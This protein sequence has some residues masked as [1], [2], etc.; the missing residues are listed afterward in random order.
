MGTHADIV[1]PLPELCLRA[2]G[3]SG[4]DTDTDAADVHVAM[5]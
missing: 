4:A 5:A 1:K 3:L 2:F